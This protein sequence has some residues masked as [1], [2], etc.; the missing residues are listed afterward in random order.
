MILGVMRE[1]FDYRMIVLEGSEEGFKGVRGEK[2][3]VRLV[4]MQRVCNLELG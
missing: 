3:W 1:L 4:N 2:N